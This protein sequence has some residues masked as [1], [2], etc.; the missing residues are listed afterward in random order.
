VFFYAA[1]TR[2]PLGTAVTIQFLGPLTLSAALSRRMRDLGWVLLAVTGVAILGLAE[3][4]GTTAGGSLSLAGVAFALV[5]AAFWAMYIVTGARASAAVPGR[6][7]LAVAMTTGAVILLPFGARGAAHIAWHPHLVLLAVGMATLAS[8]VPYSLELAAMRRAPKRVFGILLS[9]EPAVATMAGWLLLG[10]HAAP[11]A[12]AAV[13]IV[14]A[15]STGCTLG[16]TPEPRQLPQQGEKVA[17]DR[18]GLGSPLQQL[19]HRAAGRLSADVG[20]PHRVP[21]PGA[22]DQQ[23]GAARPAHRR[24]LL[25]EIR[26]EEGQMVHAL[27]VLGE[28]RRVRGEV[29]ERLEQFEQHAAQRAEGD[30][31]RERRG[32]ATDQHPVEPRLLPRAKERSGAQPRAQL[33]LRGGAVAHHPAN[34]EQLWKPRRRH[35]TPSVSTTHTASPTRTSLPSGTACSTMT[36]SPVASTCWLIFSVSISYS[37]SPLRNASPGCR[38]NR[39]IVASSIVIPIFGSLTRTRIVLTGAPLSCR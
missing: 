24:E 21:R 31:Q 35:A 38:K 8:V 28:E 19:D 20:P 37:G 26:H 11:A 16:A 29:I 17:E 15:A 23:I 13:V 14:V 34:V 30:P 39:T 22:V 36:P 18:L 10:Q 5:S 9:L 1:L 33:L 7:G 6:G 27:A 2:L 32:L 3:G 12:L 4:D 25:V